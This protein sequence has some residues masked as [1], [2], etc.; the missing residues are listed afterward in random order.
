M[1]RPLR[2]LVVEDSESDA[3]L[4]LLALKKGGFDPTFER[5]Q[6]EPEMRSAL[7]RGPWDLVLSD[8][9]MPQFSAPAAFTVLS[10]KNVDIPFIILSGTVDEETAVEAMR[11]GAHDFMAKGKL[12]RLVPA[13][14]RELREC[15]ERKARRHAEETLKKTEQQLHHAQKLEAIGQLASGV[16]HDFNNLLSVILGSAEMIL[17]DLKPDDPIRG[18]I[19]EIYKAGTRAADLTRQLL[20]FSRQQVLQPRILDLNQVLTGIEKMVGRLLGADVHVR[21]VKGFGL[22]RSKADPGQIEQVI[23]NL[24]VNARD[25]MPGGGTLTLE[26][27]NA[28]LHEDYAREHHGVD[29]GP[30]VLLSVTDTGTGMDAAT[31]ARI[32]EPFFTTKERGKGTGLGLSTVFGIVEQSHGHIWVESEPGV[33]T[34]FKVYLPRTDAKVQETPSVPPPPSVRGSETILLVEDDD[35]VRAVACGILQ[36]SGY[37]VLEASNGGEALLICEQHSAAI[38]LL[39]TDVVLPRMNGRQLAERILSMRSGIKVLFMSGYTDDAILR[40]GILESDVAYLQKP[41]TPSKLAHSVREVLGPAPV[42]RSTG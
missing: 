14:E 25:A 30:Y 7:D 16:A 26:T 13:I 21:I 23:T 3:E 28:E 34:S 11:L 15:E 31:K 33:G 12:T 42:R 4:T 22:G 32:F 36:R 29:A 24:V 17:S 6:T 2:V 39:L 1:P 37:R 8:Y 41:L 9:S 35:A 18:D 38:H 27:K 40:H 5:V 19:S 20:A 10:E